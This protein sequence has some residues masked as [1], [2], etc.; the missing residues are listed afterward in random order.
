M[1][2]NEQKD[3]KNTEKMVNIISKTTSKGNVEI[4]HLIKAKLIFLIKI[5]EKNL[6]NLLKDELE[7]QNCIK[8]I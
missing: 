2:K 7:D 6:L 1:E 3:Q 5:L 8:H 4:Y